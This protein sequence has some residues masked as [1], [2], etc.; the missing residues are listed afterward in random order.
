[1]SKCA[2]QRHGWS[3]PANLVLACPAHA[4]RA[5]VAGFV[6]RRAAAGPLLLASRGFR[7]GLGCLFERIWTTKMVTFVCPKK[8]I[9]SPPPPSKQT[10]KNPKYK[11]RHP[12]VNV[13]SSMHF[14]GLRFLCRPGN[15]ATRP[16]AEPSLDT[17]LRLWVILPR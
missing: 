7:P 1:M 16:G 8:R 5:R 13:E 6:A 10:D 4:S 12:G 17:E 14:W 2:I 9:V 3:A 11:A 15:L